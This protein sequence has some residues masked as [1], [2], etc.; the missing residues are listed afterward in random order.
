VGHVPYRDHQLTQVL[1]DSLGGTAKTLMFLNCSPAESNWDETLNTLR[2]G[3]RAKRVLNSGAASP[4][5][6]DESKSPK[7]V[8]SVKTLKTAGGKSKASPFFPGGLPGGEEASAGRM[9]AMTEFEDGTAGR[10]MA[11]TESQPVGTAGTLAERLMA[12]EEA[13][14][15]SAK[16]GALLPRIAELEDTLLGERGS[17]TLAER[18]DTIEESAGLST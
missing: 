11:M 18:L 12:V 5:A 13:V 16:Q 2:Y 6:G 15:G 17:G 3:T 7:T 8:K 10:A 4:K 14:L 9:R 1:Q